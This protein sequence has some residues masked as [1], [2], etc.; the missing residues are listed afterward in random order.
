MNGM[1]HDVNGA[2]LSTMRLACL[3]T[4]ATACAAVLLPLFGYGEPVGLPTLAALLGAGIG[5][6]A[7]QRTTEEKGRQS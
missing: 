5:G 4:T 3:G 1:L 2:T 6:K 7:V